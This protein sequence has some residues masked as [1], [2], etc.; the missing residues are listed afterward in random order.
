MYVCNVQRPERH[1]PRQLVV[2]LKATP[3]LKQIT[4]IRVIIHYFL[5]TYR[6]Q[7]CVTTYHGLS[8]RLIVLSSFY[9]LCTCRLGLHLSSSLLFVPAPRIPLQRSISIHRTQLTIFTNPQILLYRSSSFPHP[10][11]RYSRMFVYS[12]HGC[13]CFLRT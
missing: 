12:S 7:G 8:L 9:P 3:P 4:Y 5:S 2:F 6:L 1:T 11:T 10:R 13:H